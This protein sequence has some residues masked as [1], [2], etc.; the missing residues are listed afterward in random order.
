MSPR[1]SRRSGARPCCRCSR[2]ASLTRA[3]T[4]T[5]RAVRR[6][7]KRNGARVNASEA[8]TEQQQTPGGNGRDGQ[9]NTGRIEEIQGVVIE[10]VFPDELPEINHAIT[11]KRADT[12]EEE[13]VSSGASAVLV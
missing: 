12:G 8:S 3:R 4:M 13:G 10:A 6:W 5:S 11:I 9:R 7:A 2:R 1:W